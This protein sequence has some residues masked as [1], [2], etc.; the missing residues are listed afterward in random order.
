MKITISS[1][2]FDGGHDEAKNLVLAIIGPENMK[3]LEEKIS[4]GA[5]YSQGCEYDGVVYN[6]LDS[7]THR[8]DRTIELEGVENFN[9]V[10]AVWYQP[11]AE[12]LDPDF[13]EETLDWEVHSY[14][15]Y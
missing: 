10:S 12:M 4:L 1:K 7:D 15:L 6:T 9:W 3:R 13:D 5:E 14:E 8:L 11:A 2:N